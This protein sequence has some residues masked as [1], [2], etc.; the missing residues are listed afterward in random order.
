MDFIVIRTGDRFASAACMT[1]EQMKRRTK[2]FAVAIVKFAASLPRDPVT[3]LIAR[4][5]VKSGTSVG[6]NYR[7]SCRAKSRPDF[8]AKLT[9]AEEEADETQYWLEILVEASMVN[10]DAVDKLLDESEQLV[11]IFVA[12]IKT[13]RGFSR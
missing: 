1:P 8:V 5:L 13:A 6:A 2:A 9:T 3:E 7:S 10:R 12:S 4:Q 11:R